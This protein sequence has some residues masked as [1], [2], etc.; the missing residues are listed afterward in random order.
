[1]T[2]LADHHQ[3][4]AEELVKVRKFAPSPHWFEVIND[5]AYNLADM[6]KI[7]DSN[8]DQEKFLEV[9]EMEEVWNESS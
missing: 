8:F 7:N 4:L 9:C 1:M 2:K 6:F 5:F 3:A